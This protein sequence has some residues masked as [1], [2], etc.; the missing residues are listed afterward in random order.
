M[1]SYFSWLRVGLFRHPLPVAVEP[2]HRH[3]PEPLPCRCLFVGL[4]R[5][6]LP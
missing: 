5:Q 4:F 3:L 6:P 2:H 1:T